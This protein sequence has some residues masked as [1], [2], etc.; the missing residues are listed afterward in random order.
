MRDNLGIRG[1]GMKVKDVYKYLLAI[2]ICW[3]TLD[4]HEKFRWFTLFSY[5]EIKWN[6]TDNVKCNDFFFANFASA[7]DKGLFAEEKRPSFS[8]YI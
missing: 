8:M 4:S 1:N 7:S 2:M 3:W 6:F 5:I